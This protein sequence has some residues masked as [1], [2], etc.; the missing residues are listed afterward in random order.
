MAKYIESIRRIDT[1]TFDSVTIVQVSP[2]VS[3]FTIDAANN[4]CG[5]ADFR[6]VTEEMECLLIGSNFHLRSVKSDGYMCGH[7]ARLAKHQWR[8]VKSQ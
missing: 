1:N 3:E 2:K 4:Y 7:R 5:G 8:V 6:L